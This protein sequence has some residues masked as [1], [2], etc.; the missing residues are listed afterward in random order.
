MFY[1]VSRFLFRLFFQHIC[2]W[3]VEGRENLPRKGPVVVICNHVSYWDPIVLGAAL[4]RTVFFMAKEELFR[5]PLLAQVIRA[6]GAFPVNRN[7]SDQAAF[8]KALKL[9]KMGQ[10]LGIYPE[11]TRSK[12]GGLQPFQDG[13]FLLASLSNAPVLP[14]AV[15]DTK[16]IFSKG[17]FHTFSVRIGKPFKMPSGRLK[18]EELKEYK[19]LAWETVKGLLE[20]Q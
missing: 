9:L 18:G 2:H 13:A 19:R 10:V 16:H 3:K 5:I 17:R 12:H 1:K 8:R 6:W 4:D 15:R 20:Q 14:V 11:G 7:I